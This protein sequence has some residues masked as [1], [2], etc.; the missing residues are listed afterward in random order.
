MFAWLA[1][2]LVVAGLEL[3]DFLLAPPLVELLHLV[4][5]LLLVV[6]QVDLDWEVDQ[7]AMAVVPHSVSAR[8]SPLRAAAAVEQI[9]KLQE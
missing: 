9:I 1:V 7:A 4:L 8:V 6:I 2:V 5:P 3:A